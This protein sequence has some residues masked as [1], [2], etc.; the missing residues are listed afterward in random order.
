MQTGLAVCEGYAFVLEKLCQLQGIDNYLIRGDTKT[1]FKDIGR[2][3]KKNHLW[4]AIKLDEQWQ[5]FDA[6][7]GAGTYR[8]KFY[9][10]PSYF[11]YTIA[12]EQL[13]KSHYPAVVEDAFLENPIAYAEFSKAPLILSPQLLLSHIISPKEGYVNSKSSMNTVYFKL[14]IDPPT[15]IHFGYG[16]NKQELQFEVKEGVVHFIVPVQMGHDSLLIYFDGKP[17][18][19]YKVI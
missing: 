1:H 8:D 7:W 15:A 13:I 16:P 4:N 11:Y 12:P 6:T 9:K 5:L 3:F 2:S 14:Q 17:I 10:E 19:G 18:L